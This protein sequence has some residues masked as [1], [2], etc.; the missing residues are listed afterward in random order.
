MEQNWTQAIFVVAKH[1]NSKSVHGE[2][3]HS[4]PET[5]D[6]TIQNYVES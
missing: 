4:K 1:N 6:C 3:F 5:D 2:S